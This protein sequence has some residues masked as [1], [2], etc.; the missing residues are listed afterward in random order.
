MSIFLRQASRANTKIRINLAAPAG[1][2]KSYSALRLAYGLCG[3]WTKVAVI[4]TENGSA[5]LYEHLGPYNVVS[6]APEFSVAKY[7]EAIK[8]CE[9][10]G[11]EVIIIDSISHE[12]EWCLEQHALAT[13]A[14]R[15]K[16]SYT[17]WGKVT[18]LHNRFKN[19]ILQSKCHV[20]TCVRTEQAYEMVEDGGKKSVKR[21]GM[22]QKTRGGWNYEVTLEFEVD[23]D[24]HKAISSKDRTEMFLKPA[25][26]NELNIQKPFVIT[27]ETGKMIRQWCES[28]SANTEAILTAALV[29]V[30]TADTIEDLKSIWEGNKSLQTKQEFVAAMSERK[31]YLN[32]LTQQ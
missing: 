23:L 30:N 18:P 9:Q 32:S 25:L 22:G 19:A 4:D 2:G 31:G 10:A 8:V 17:A 1:G 3:D 29:S 7:I 26:N 28:E 16:N 12:R 20:I 11:M 24:S 5:D 6:L 21:M 14:A 15:A 13:E 27:E